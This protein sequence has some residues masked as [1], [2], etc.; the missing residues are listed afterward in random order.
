MAE[1]A[2][3]ARFR[4]LCGELRARD[5]VL[6]LEFARERK[7]EICTVYFRAA[8]IQLI[9]CRKW[10]L[11]APPSVLFAR[12]SFSKNSP[13]FLHLPELIAYLG[14]EDYRACYFPYL[15]TPMRLEAAFGTL[16]GILDDYLPDLE[17]MAVTGEGDDMIRRA[18]T[19]NFFDDREAPFEAAVEDETVY[20]RTTEY[21]DVMFEC[22]M[23]G[24]FTMDAYESFVMGRWDQA[25]K[26][27]RKMDKSG[28][29]AYERG[30]IRFM[31]DS[32]NR[33]FRAMPPECSA[34]SGYQKASG[35]WKDL[36][37]MLMLWMSVSAVLCGLTILGNGFLSRGTVFFFGMP[38]WFGMLLAPFPAV[39]A[40]AV[41]Q[42]KIL[43]WMKRQD[44]VAYVSMSEESHPILTRILR[45]LLIASVVGCLGFTVYMLGMNERFY[46]D[47]G[48]CLGE[49]GGKV[50]F[51]YSEIE[52]LCFIESRYNVYGDRVN[53]GSWV[54]VLKDGVF[55]DLD[56]NASRKQQEQLVETLFAE[57]PQKRL[58]SD[59]DLPGN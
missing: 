1:N 6:Y 17:R 25:L 40:Y 39:L 15:E 42:K 3:S 44:E 14:R 13:A 48:V 19:L 53:R 49:E 30:L 54:I 20:R 38:W 32:K 26:R 55:F 7:M 56:G 34:H 31:E 10:E 37:G 36:L 28:L 18:Q 8:K 50:A 47:H 22:L 35:T 23:V 21:L 5:D 24:R 45:I 29:S 58:D 11:L 46:P 27:Y 16:I 51:S 12:V 33:G 52:S 9:Y 57:Y 41:F 2:M 4:E 59:R 43:V